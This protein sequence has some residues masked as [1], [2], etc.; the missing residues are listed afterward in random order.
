MTPNPTI[1]FG[2]LVRRAPADKG[3]HPNFGGRAID[4]ASYAEGVDFDHGF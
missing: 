3:L 1:P 2:K 4:M